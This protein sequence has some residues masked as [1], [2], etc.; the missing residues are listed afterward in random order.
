MIKR[1]VG[2]DDSETYQ[3]LWRQ[4]VRECRNESIAN[5]ERNILRV[6]SEVPA[7]DDAD[8]PYD[9][10]EAAEKSMKQFGLK[11]EK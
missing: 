4:Y 8:Y 1:K 9:K 10:Y 3:R 6:L 2:Y 7:S 5:F 11:F